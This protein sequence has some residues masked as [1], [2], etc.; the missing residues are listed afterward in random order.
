LWVLTRRAYLAQAKFAA[1]VNGLDIEFH[2]LS[3]YDIAQLGERFNVVPF[4]DVLSKT[5]SLLAFSRDLSSEMATSTL[6]IH[7]MTWRM[8]QRCIGGPW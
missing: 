7:R 8:R 4:L 5:S 6:R 2:Q 3:V 1:E